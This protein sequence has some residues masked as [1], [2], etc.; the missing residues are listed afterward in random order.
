MTDLDSECRLELFLNNLKN[1]IVGKTGFI[2]FYGL[3]LIQVYNHP[4]I[5][6]KV[7]AKKIHYCGKILRET[8]FID[9]VS[10][11]DLSIAIVKELLKNKISN[12]K[13]FPRFK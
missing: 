13:N 11:T 2:I 3:E 7:S 12:S 10:F 8:D 6:P 4:L 1:Y 9:L 5:C